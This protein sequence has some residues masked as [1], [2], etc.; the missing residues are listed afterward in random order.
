MTFAYH[1]ASY[2]NVL[3]SNGMSPG[4]IE[5]VNSRWFF[6]PDENSSFTTGQM[7]EILKFMEGL[8]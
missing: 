4:T 3:Y 6:Y 2:Y 1:G 7:K 8:S 5:R